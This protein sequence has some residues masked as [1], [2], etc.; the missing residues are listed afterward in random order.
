MIDNALEQRIGEATHRLRR[1]QRWATWLHGTWCLLAAAALLVLADLLVPLPVGL[2]RLASV[3]WL[4][5]WLAAAGLGFAAA[6]AVGRRSAEFFAALLERSRDAVDNALINAVQFSRTLAAGA[7]GGA[8]DVLMR[9]EIERGRHVAVY[10]PAGSNVDGGSLRWHGRILVWVV[11]MMAAAGGAWPD[12]WAAILPR[13]YDP[14]GDHP[15]YCPTRFDVRYETDRPDALAYYGDSV[16][17]VITLSGRHI[18]DTAW[19]SVERAEGSQRI[20]LFRRGDAEWFVRFDNVQE[21]LRFRVHTPRGYSTWQTFALVPTPR[22]TDATV[23]YEPPTYTGRMPYDEPF[24]TA[25]IRALRG[26]AVTLL[27]TSNRSLSGGEIR[28]EGDG[29]PAVSFAMTPLS[30]AS[31]RVAGSFMMQA[32]GRMT[33]VVTSS[34]GLRSHD[35]LEAP[36][37][38]IEDAAPT[39]EIEEPGQ[40]AFAVATASIPVQVYASDDVGITQVRLHWSVNEAQADT[41]D[42]SGES[43][44]GAVVRGRHLFDLPALGLKAGDVLDYYATAVDNYPD[45]PHA[46]DS[47]LYRIAVVSQDDYAEMARQ[48]VGIEWLRSQYEPLID[49]FQAIADEIERLAKEAEQIAADLAAAPPDSALAEDLRRRLDALA[50]AD[51][52]VRQRAADLAKRMDDLAARPPVYDVQKHLNEELGQLSKQLK[53]MASREGGQA[54]ADALEKPDA[55]N[56][57]VAPAVGRVM[58]D[59]LEDAAACKGEACQ[60]TC[61]S[62]AQPVET[63]VQV[64]ELMALT[65]TFKVLATAQRDLAR[66]LQPFAGED[67]R[68]DE[69]RLTLK[70]YAADQR[71]IA[72]NVAELREKF[73][74]KGRAVADFAA[75]LAAEA[76][77]ETGKGLSDVE[78]EQLVQRQARAQRLDEFARKAFELADTM[79]ELAIVEEMET[80]AGHLDAYRGEPGHEHAEQAAQKM[81]SMIKKCSAAAGQ[82]SSCL[83]LDIIEFGQ[84][85]EQMMQGL[86]AAMATMSTGSGGVGQGTGG[87]AVGGFDAAIYGMEPAAGGADSKR[88]KRKPSL[89]QIEATGVPSPASVE[90]IAPDEPVPLDVGAVRG[91]SVPARYKAVT[92]AYF[93][94]IAEEGR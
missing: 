23:R 80:A 37:F 24:A 26:T 45:E 57:D 72:E 61:K 35:V 47:R 17:A 13:F 7:Q 84:S 71:R 29:V 74:E 79:G 38:V 19:L 15:P 69:D 49:E 40:D 30:D 16:R 93:R 6:R 25:G 28:F 75:Q 1:A 63:L 33:A 10:T 73:T 51:A 54:L 50:A 81:L 42:L 32:D 31:N 18:P 76:S 56:R 22:I 60:S 36:V 77:V 9:A 8:S 34:A 70:R 52:A 5:G 58:T 88:P 48:E 27:L 83:S 82:G 14:A 4:I 64:Y 20:D 59:L 41:A 92:E 3:A 43:A 65:E 12:V 2:R 53:K 44:G 66:K 78:R 91:E 85:L 89:R 68:A 86:R 11:V 87:F 90:T 55:T 21:D 67:K 94:R 39:V 62:V 46:V